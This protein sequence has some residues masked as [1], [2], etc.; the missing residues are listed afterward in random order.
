MPECCGFSDA[1]DVSGLEWSLARGF[2]GRRGKGCADSSSLESSACWV[3]VVSVCCCDVGE[4]FVCAFSSSVRRE[5]GG[6]FESCVE[7]CA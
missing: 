2:W 5:Y 3:V 4:E 6:E 7:C 1:E